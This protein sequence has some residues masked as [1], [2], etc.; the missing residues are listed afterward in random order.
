MSAASVGRVVYPNMLINFAMAKSFSLLE[1]AFLALILTASACGRD[2][3]SAQGVAEE[4]V[5]QHYVVIDLPK[6]KTLAVSV[7]LSKLNEEIRLTS[8]QPI[9]ASTRKPRV[10]YTLL[11]KKEGDQRATFLY[12]GTIQ[13]DDN[14]S[15]TRQWLITAR[16]EGTQWRVSN[17]TESD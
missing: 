16:R 5:D 17:F 7:A 13:S 14:T 8:G 11:E 2:L 9:D 1:A 15:F 10:H 4:F 12:Q 3:N 6:A